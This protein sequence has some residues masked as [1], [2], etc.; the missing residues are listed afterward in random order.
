L[1]HFGS[2]VGTRTAKL[3]EKLEDLVSVLRSQAIPKSPAETSPDTS[4][5]AS[6]AGH[7]GSAPSNNLLSTAAHVPAITTPI[8][9]SPMPRG[10]VAFSPL[11]PAAT[12]LDSTTALSSLSGSSSRNEILDHVA[13][14]HLEVF[15]TCMLNFFPFVY[16]PPSSTAKDLRHERPFF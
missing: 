15:C 5:D 3:D 9:A 16:V 6:L 1:I 14:D 8:T 12:V 13:G 7:N 4:R 10:G 2:L 11:T